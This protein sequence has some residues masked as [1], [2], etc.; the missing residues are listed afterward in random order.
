MRKF[1]YLYVV[2]LMALMASTLHAFTVPQEDS[3]VEYFY[4]TGP[5]GDPTRGAEDHVQILYIDVPGDITDP[6]EISVYDPDTGGSIDAKPSRRNKWDTK[7]E[8][9]IYGSKLLDQ[10]QFDSEGYDKE[11]YV[12]GPYDKSDGEPVGNYYRFAIEV[13]ATEGDDAN[14]FNV[15]ILPN[16][17]KVFSTNISFRL[18]P[19]K[20]DDMYF[21]PRVPN[22]ESSVTVE[23]YD[24]DHNGGIS[25]LHDTLNEEEYLIKDSLS[26]QW[27]ETTINL[28]STQDRYL[29]YHIVKGT[30]KNAHA[31]LRIKDSNGNLLPIYFR[32]ETLVVPPAPVEVT[33]ERPCNE[34]TF[35]ATKSF[36][37][38]N[39]ALT[40][41]WDFGDGTTSTEPIVTHTF[42]SGGMYNVMLT[43]SDN[44][45]LECE[46]SVAAQNVDI[47]SP[48][49]AAL[50]APDIACTDQTVMFD[51]SGTTDNTIDQVTYSWNFGDGTTGEGQSI[52]KSFAKG[53]TYRVQL[54][55]NDNADTV[56]S[57]DGITKTIKI[58]TPPVANAGQDIDLCLPANA[59]Y[60]VSFRGAGSTDADGDE[61]TYSWD[62]G[63]GTTGDG[64]NVSHLYTMSGQY[65]VRL[66]VNDNSE[67]ACSISDDTILVNLNKSPIAEA[68]DNQIT[69]TGNEVIFDGSGSSVEPGDVISY[70]W[71]FGDGAT[72]VGQTVSHV[73]NQGGNYKATLTVDDGKGTRCSVSTDSLNVSVNSL[74]TVIISAI[75]TACTGETITF[76]AS[77]SSDDDGDTMSYSW[78]FG[79]GTTGEGATASHSYSQ[80]GNYPV[81]LTVDDGKGTQCSTVT[82]NIVASVNAPP[83]VDIVPIG[84]VCTG[85]TVMFDASGT[86][87]AD[88][89]PLTY[90]WDFGDGTTGEGATVSHAY[91]QGGNYK[92]VLTVDD[93]KGTRCSVAS[94]SVPVSVNTIPSAIISS[95]DPVSTGQTITFDGS[96]SGD[97]DGDSLTYSWDFGDGSTGNGATASHAYSQGGNYPVLLTVDDGKGTPCSV[98]SYN[99]V[100]S[101]NTP[102]V[103]ILSPID[104]VCVGD[105]VMFDASGTSD[106]DG[107]PLTYSWDFGDG[108]TGDGPTPSHTYS[109]GGTYKAVVTVN[110]GKGTS[111]SIASRSIPVE[112]NTQPSAVLSSIDT[113]CTGEE[114]AFNGSGS[115]DAD[116]DALTYTWDFGDGTVIQG[117]PNASHSYSK[118]GNYVVTLKA[119][120]NKE[121]L[122]STAT[123]AINV[124]VNTPPVADAGPNLV[125][126]LEEESI[127]DGS[128][129]FDPDGDALSYSW[130]FGD[131]N[132]GQGAKVTHVYEKSGT[133]TVTLTVN[134]NSGTKCSTAV[135][136]FRADVNARPSAI[137]QVK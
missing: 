23:N 27:K 119:D 42:P 107:D 51:A 19:G 79:D 12:F 50:Y 59:S 33:G 128:G 108:N 7:T 24:L 48:P 101:V 55:V 123:T 69:C 91:G 14:L 131:G 75:D 20:G 31:A 133:F 71:D 113:V 132:T 83:L 112:V 98:V 137:I 63:D 37:P 41:L 9:S 6:L 81:L 102:P 53:G 125:C 129:S 111:G 93:G 46:T 52:A 122:C 26:G 84:I 115:E 97:A 130:N 38:D 21:Y 58:N 136:S 39:Q 90:S 35:D 92:A 103:I 87:D 47:N 44:S 49:K 104:V 40:F 43:V 116:G 66:V 96:G 78:D 73:Y 1:T 117:G 25:H 95:V 99:I 67:S 15:S 85:D 89:D 54:M 88:G 56:C 4:V 2:V 135:D 106:A 94:R 105:T 127:F 80:G 86:S 134:D 17:A 45:G 5:K 109:Q 126:C 68:G 74:P 13:K 62:F 65:T 3:M 10:K 36:D 34:L 22:G 29:Q 121:T 120:D 18:L 30:Q 76:D 100:A 64:A 72:A 32:P 82:Y 28:S 8:I 57:H 118:G 110:D 124:K 114:V 60:D 77:G 16:S 70:N 61:L 11:Y